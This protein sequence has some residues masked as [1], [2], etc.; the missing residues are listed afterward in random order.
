MLALYWEGTYYCAYTDKDA[1]AICTKWRLR[2]PET[3]VQLS[4]SLAD[5]CGESVCNKG[6]NTIGH[7]VDWCVSHCLQPNQFIGRLVEEEEKEKEK[8]GENR[9]LTDFHV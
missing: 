6:S 1:C 5:S 7:R 3:P 8:D 9:G 2:H 4:F